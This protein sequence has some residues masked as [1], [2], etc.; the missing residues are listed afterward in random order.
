MSQVVKIPMGHGCVQAVQLHRD[1]LKGRFY[2]ELNRHILPAALLEMPCTARLHSFVYR[3][4][5][6]YSPLPHCL[7]VRIAQKPGACA[8]A[9]A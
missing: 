4:P 7:L 9:A 6:C 8:S 1:A 3:G 5:P 2:R